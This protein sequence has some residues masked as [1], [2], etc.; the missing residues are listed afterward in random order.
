METKNME[1]HTLHDCFSRLFDGGERLRREVRLTAEQA[2]WAV[3]HYPAVLTPL[4]DGW[5]DMEFQGAY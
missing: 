3:E 4:G 2:R 1:E 5:Y